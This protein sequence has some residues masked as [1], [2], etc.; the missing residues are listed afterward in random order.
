M[1]KL[2]SL[3]EEIVRQLSLMNFDRGLTLQEQITHS[4]RLGKE[5]QFQPTKDS[6]NNQ[7]YW[8]NATPEQISNTVFNTIKNEINSVSTDED[9]IYYALKKL[10]FKT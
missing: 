10:N 6:I 4:D 7:N 8:L 9:K 1:G 3:N 5:G 2:I